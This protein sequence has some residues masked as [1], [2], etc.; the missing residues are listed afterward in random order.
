MPDFLDTTTTTNTGVTS[1]VAPEDQLAYDSRLDFL[2]KFPTIFGPA[3][4]KH[5]LARPNT[6]EYQSVLMTAWNG[7]I[8]GTFSIGIPTLQL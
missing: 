4:I 1:A 3:T 8:T 5:A 6:T 2:M 7:R